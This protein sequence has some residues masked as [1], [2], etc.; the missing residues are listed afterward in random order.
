MIQKVIENEQTD[1]C[2]QEYQQRLNE[3]LMRYSLLIKTINALDDE[4][5]KSAKVRLVKQFNYCMR[6]KGKIEA[7]IKKIAPMI[8][9][10]LKLSP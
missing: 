9:K 4:L 5:K 1:N 6:E 10:E 3:L 2:R 8:A 7:E